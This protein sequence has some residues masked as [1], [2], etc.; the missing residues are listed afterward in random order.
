[1]KFLRYL[2]V[3]M[4][5]S[6]PAHA[7]GIAVAD[8]DY[9]MNET[10]AARDI[11]EQLKTQTEKFQQEY[12]TTEA[13]LK[14]EEKSLLEKR[15]NLTEAEFKK[16]IE[17]FQKKMADESKKFQNKKAK[18]DKAFQEALRE[19]QKEVGL[20]IQ[21]IAREKEIVYV[22]SKKD[23]LFAAAGQPD[24]TEDVLK[25]LNEK[26]KTIPVSIK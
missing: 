21:E 20:T 3:L 14:K 25:R 12:K 2:F 23:V 8:A 18:L 16:Q 24:L 5:L 1:M 11:K 26:T 15:P 17:A 19:L 6:V 22:L 4:I 10:S 9:L 7:Q 13:V